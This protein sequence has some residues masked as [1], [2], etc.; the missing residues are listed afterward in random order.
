MGS[1]QHRGRRPASRPSPQRRVGAGPHSHAPLSQDGLLLRPADAQP[2]PAPGARVRA[3]PLGPKLLCAAGPSRK[4]RDFPPR[5]GDGRRGTG[6]DW[7]AGGEE[8][9]VPGGDPAPRAGPGPPFPPRSLVVPAEYPPGGEILLHAQQPLPQ[10][11]QHRRRHR[12]SSARVSDRRRRPR[13]AHLS[14][15]RPHPRGRPAPGRPRPRP[16]RSP[17]RVAPPLG[18]LAPPRA[19]RAAAVGRAGL[20]CGRGA[21]L[22]SPPGKREARARSPCQPRLSRFAL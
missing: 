13:P 2:I 10:G 22:P 19:G 12:V 16:R 5:S 1:R 9:G 3:S 14:P 6:L 18:P 8:G 7:G 15:A 17:F 21:A 4:V 11:L 20:G